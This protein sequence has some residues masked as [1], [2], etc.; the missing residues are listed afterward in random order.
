MFNIIKKHIW[1]Y[2]LEIVV[3]IIIFALL[4]LAGLL[5][6]IYIVLLINIYIVT[7]YLRKLIKVF[8]VANEM[9]LVAITRKLKIT[10][11]EIVDIG[12]EVNRNL[13]KKQQADL[14]KDIRDIF[15][16]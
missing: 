12:E 4:D 2:V 10:N 8:Q 6:Y 7:D 3:A 9:K 5:V 14:E 15:P 16:F 11:K 13:S 1:M